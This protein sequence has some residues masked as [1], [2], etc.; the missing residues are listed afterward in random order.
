M[1]LSCGHDDRQVSKMIRMLIVEDDAPA[2]EMTVRAL[3]SAGVECSHEVVASE[4]DFRDALARA[5]DVI[6]SDSNVPGFD[7]M[8]ALSIAKS[9]SPRVPFI[10]VSGSKHAVKVRA[11]IAGGAAAYVCKSDLTGLALTVLS[12]LDRG[13]EVKTRRPERRRR[14][15]VDPLQLTDDR[16]LAAI[17]DL[18]RCGNRQMFEYRF[19]RE[20]ECAMRLERPIALLMCDIDNF[21]SVNDSHGLAIGDEVMR[22][23][24]ARIMNNLRQG[25]DWVARLSSDEFAVVLP[26]VG[27]AEA[28]AVARRL[29]DNVSATAFAMPPPCL[30]VTASFG[31]CAWGDMRGDPTAVRELLVKSAE[32]ALQRSKRD[33]RNRVAAAQYLTDGVEPKR[34]P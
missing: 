31:V 34:D 24:A 8:A 11:A 15:R 32:A 29:C 3:E 30:P 5:P 2:A 10:F 26:A 1:L 14:P 25:A 4:G 19:P 17:D 20:V 21:R 13:A 28:L 27:T 22:D 12:A 9:E 7:G 6:L 18:T 23:F 16:M 33:G